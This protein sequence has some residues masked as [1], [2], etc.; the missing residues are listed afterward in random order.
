MK[1]ELHCHTKYSDDSLLLFHAL[2]WKCVACGI[3]YI[4][5][6]EHNN[7]R[8]AEA[9]ASFCRKRGNKV[10]VIKGEEIFTSQGEIIGLFLDSEIGPGLSP[11]ETILRIRE[12]NG[13]VYVPHPYDQK[14]KK[15]VLSEEA[16]QNNLDQID[17]IECHNGRNVLERY[18][19]E[20]NAIAEKYAITKVI[21]SDAHTVLEIGRNVIE[22]KD[23]VLN[24]ET[25]LEVIKD[26]YFEKKSC[27]V[28]AHKITKIVRA[29]KM[30][31]KGQFYEV[32]RIFL[33]RIK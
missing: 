12:Q 21:G 17:C 27:L 32:C 13:I 26:G 14:R 33:K 29:V 25:F 20:Q 5:I 1:I 23:C 16:I 2:Y 19:I 3:R 7:L 8:G 10:S 24:R 6:T 9:F 28:I 31:W 18:G 4:A 30:I 22:T 11:E 15:T